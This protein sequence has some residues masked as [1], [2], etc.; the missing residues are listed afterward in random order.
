MARNQVGYSGLDPTPEVARNHVAERVIEIN[1]TSNLCISPLRDMTEHPVFRWHPPEASA[2]AIRPYLLVGSDDPGVFGTELAFEYAALSRAAEE[3]GAAPREI[4]RWLRDLRDN[5]KMFCFLETGRGTATRWR[6]TAS[7]LKPVVFSGWF[8]HHL[9]AV[10]AA[11]S[12]R[13]TRVRRNQGRIPPDVNALSTICITLNHTR[14]R[15]CPPLHYP[16]TAQTRRGM[17][18]TCSHRDDVNGRSMRV[19]FRQ[20]GSMTSMGP[21]VVY[22]YSFFTPWP[23]V[24]LRSGQGRTLLHPPFRPGRQR[25]VAHLAPFFDHASFRRIGFSTVARRIL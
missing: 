13:S 22:Q 3:R 4:E 18:V 16:R 5:S 23:P 8:R 25:F 17:V 9:W 12:P 1:P 11:P 24:R 14:N 15:E 10:G 20:S 6:Q 21:K 2:E 7:I 19:P